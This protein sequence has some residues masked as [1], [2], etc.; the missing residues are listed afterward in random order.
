[1]FPAP[2]SLDLILSSSSSSVQPAGS[3]AP[4]APSSFLLINRAWYDVWKQTDRVMETRRRWQRAA[5]DQVF[6]FFFPFILFSL[7]S[8][9]S[10][11]H[12]AT[13]NNARDW[14]FFL[15]IQTFQGKL[16]TESVFRQERNLIKNVFIICGGGGG[17]DHNR[18]WLWNANPNRD[19]RYGTTWVLFWLR[20][21]KLFLFFILKMF[22]LFFFFCRVAQF[23]PF[24][25]TQTS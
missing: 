11:I 24:C 23:I 22:S 18:G 2:C 12:P 6:F 20:L 17:G 16:L 10:T 5:T 19:A 25:K 1:M 8:L 9:V 3:P 21:D 4:F 14:L 13:M 7:C 15:N